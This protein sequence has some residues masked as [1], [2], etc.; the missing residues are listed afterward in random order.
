MCACNKG[1]K[2]VSREGIGGKSIT[3]TNMRNLTPPRQQSDKVQ[4]GKHSSLIQ[5]QKAILDKRQD[6]IRKSLNK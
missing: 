4:I 2:N 5:H 6:A 1:M 3:N